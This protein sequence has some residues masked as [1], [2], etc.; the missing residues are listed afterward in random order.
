MAQAGSLSEG[1]QHYVPRFYLQ[2]FAFP[3]EGKRKRRRIFVRDRVERRTYPA[4][5]RD[6]ASEFGFYDATDEDGSPISVDPAITKL[7]AT[8]APALQRLVDD[9]TPPLELPLGEITGSFK[10]LTADDQWAIAVFCATLMTRVPGRRTRLR[11]H[12]D[13]ILAQARILQQR[14]MPDRPESIDYLRWDDNTI[15]RETGATIIETAIGLANIIRHRIWVLSTPPAGERLITSDDPVIRVFSEQWVETERLVP[16][17]PTKLLG[18]VDKAVNPDSP[19]CVIHTLSSSDV[20]WHNWM[21]SERG[22]RFVYAYD[23]SD[24]ASI[25]RGGPP[26]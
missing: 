16:I 20:A 21:Q 17:S 13:H 1:K 7:E 5:I 12:N 26:R 24:F 15:A 14:F 22:T 11:A 25:A 4:P 18:F 9:T 23:Q 8:I 10:P 19:H 2:N 3:A 6:T